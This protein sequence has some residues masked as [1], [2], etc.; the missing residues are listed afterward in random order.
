MRDSRAQRP[1]STGSS[2]RFA[3]SLAKGRDCAHGRWTAWACRRV[4]WCED[5]EEDDDALLSIEMCRRG[6]TLS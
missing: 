5:G 4:K 1:I 2:L 3:L 6:K